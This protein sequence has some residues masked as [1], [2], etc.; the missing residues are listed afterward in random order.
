MIIPRNATIPPWPS[1]PPMPPEQ[2][3]P[4]RGGWSARLYDRLLEQRIVMAHGS[5]DD[6]AA[7]RLC[8]QLLTLDAEASQPIRLELQNLDAELDAALSVMGVLDA[9]RAPVAAYVAGR[10]H[11]PALGLLALA[12]HRFAYPS[13]MF[14]LREP[15][16]RCDGTVAA[17]ASH[18]QEVTR[19]LDELLSRLA[20][21]TGRDVQ[22]IRSDFDAQ[23]LLTVDE[24]IEYGL[25]ERRAQPRRPARTGLGSG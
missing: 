8:A 25:I 17:V 23:R 12:D 16:T 22:Q 24:A 10:I 3:P 5:L 20:Q 4:D 18:Q 15:Q 6:E 9:L 14:V 13:A 2:I 19:M 21:T 1:T 7:T 11:G